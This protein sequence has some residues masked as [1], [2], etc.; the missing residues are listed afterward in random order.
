MLAS[1]GET[2]VGAGAVVEGSAVGCVIWPG[3][4]VGADEHLIRAIRTS[5]GLTVQA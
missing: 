1:G 3:G 4:R 2:V 5:S